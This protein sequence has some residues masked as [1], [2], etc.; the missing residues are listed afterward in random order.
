MGIAWVVPF[1]KPL[2]NPLLGGLGVEHTLKLK[3]VG[4][5]FN[6]ANASSFPVMF[7]VE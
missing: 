1:P 4:A 5:P 2:H 3:D 7:G 6:R